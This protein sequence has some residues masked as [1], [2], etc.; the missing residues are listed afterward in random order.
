MSHAIVNSSHMLHNVT[1]VNTPQKLLTD[2]DT[3]EWLN[4]MCVTSEETSPA[5]LL[6]TS[7]EV[8]SLGLLPSACLTRNWNE[9]CG[10]MGTGRKSRVT[11][12]VKGKESY[13][14][15]AYSPFP[16]IQKRTVRLTKIQEKPR[17]CTRLYMNR[18]PFFK[19]VK[20]EKRSRAV[21]YSVQSQRDALD[22]NPVFHLG[23]SKLPHNYLAHVF[24]AWAPSPI[25]RICWTLPANLCVHLP[26]FID[27]AS[28]GK[29]Y[30]PWQWM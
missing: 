10:H 6:H 20:A 24:L 8:R 26:P 18:Y 4:A 21:S 16:K 25:K 11:V 23:G 19:L 29:K 15:S 13:S 30:H 3:R 22:S 17:S 27:L 2:E 28:S 7:A 5:A 12:R 14:E 9:C 1:L